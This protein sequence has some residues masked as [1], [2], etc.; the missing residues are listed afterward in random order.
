[1]AK[2]NKNF[3]K[4]K[5]SWSEIKDRLLGWYLRP[6]FQKVLMSRRPIYYVDCFAGQG[7]FGDGK[8][9]S[10]IIALQ[11]RDACLSKTTLGN[12]TAKI[13]VCFI[14]LNHAQQ[15]S[16]NIAEF[17][18]NYGYPS[19]ISGKYEET[20]GELLSG[21]RG[22]NV[23]LYI[24]PYG[25]RAL[26]YEL[27][28]KFNSYGFHSLEMLINFN[29]FGFFR[30]A[31]RAMGVAYN[32]DEALRDLD[33]LVEYAPTEINASPQSTELLS[34]IAGGDYWKEIVTRYNHGEI[35]GYKAERIFSTEYKARLR[36]WFNYVLDMPI[37]LK[38]GHRPKYRMVHVCNHEDG[39]FLMAQNMHQRKDELFT[40][41]QQNRQPSLLNLI[42]NITSTI[43][44]DFMTTDEIKK[45][46]V[47]YLKKLNGEIGLR[48]LLAGFLNEHGLLC[49][50][51]ML[52]EI[53]EDLN[54]Q[55]RIEITRTPAITLTGK[56][57]SFWEEKKD[58]R[59]TIRRKQ[60]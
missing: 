32:N 47:T 19:V 18:N 22:T 44:N 38:S 55:G 37:R 7:K 13:D 56:P 3:F 60:L 29:S 17:N 23:F 35:D 14:E 51:N 50:F 12:T 4:S 15:L 59:I 24:D 30:D 58:R 52:H 26:D 16:E 36:Q 25:I 28:E 34:K 41:I 2:D 42:G 39:C 27:F 6:Y 49:E 48:K 40:N 20:I 45:L 31:C 9:G 11:A 21:K 57:S 5:N 33:D 1:M 46:L 53:L 10:P 43:E 8:P 54:K